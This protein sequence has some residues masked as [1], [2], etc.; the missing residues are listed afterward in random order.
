MLG[1]DRK[2]FL[3]YILSIISSYYIFPVCAA[4]TKP[5]NGSTNYI[6]RTVRY[7][8]DIGYSISGSEVRV[9][10]DDGTGWTNSDPTCGR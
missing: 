2:V 3:A 5:D 9:C 6:D 10:N 4:V 1:L 8:C 7:S